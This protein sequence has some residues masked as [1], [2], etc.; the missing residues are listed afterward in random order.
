MISVVRLKFSFIPILVTL[1]VAGFVNILHGQQRTGK[2]DL[3]MISAHRGASAVAPENTLVAFSKAGELGADF[4]EIDVRTTADGAQIILHD[5]SLKR[6]TGLDSK[7]EKTSLIEIKKLSA[8]HWFGSQ[9]EDQRVPTLAE[10]CELVRNENMNRTRK[11]NLYVDCKAIDAGEVVRIL[12]QHSLLESAVFYG[13][14]NTLSEIKKF[15]E[16]ARLMPAYPGKEK[17]EQVIR[18]IAPYAVDVSYDQLDAATVSFCHAKGIKVFSD[19]LGE[20]DTAAAYRKAIQL[21]VDL[22]QTDNISGV[23]KVFDEF[24]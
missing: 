18:K 3:P 10:V 9:Y 22:I 12:S 8:G 17:M 2:R 11:V 14:M 7:V 19:L 15:Y 16:K 23:R 1:L 20:D 6:T 5:G 24:E 4:I 13:D 21:E